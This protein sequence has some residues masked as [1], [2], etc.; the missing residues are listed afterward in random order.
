[1]WS[2]GQDQAKTLKKELQMLLPE[3]RVFVDVDDLANLDDLEVLVERSSLV[4]VF[5]SRGF[6][7]SPNVL[8]EVRATVAS[9]RHVAVV[10]ETS[11]MHGAV[12][13]AELRAQ[14]EGCADPVVAG[15]APLGLARGV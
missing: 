5:L 2:S 12:P 6:F 11:E 15:A 9:G 3:L 13:L 14:C 1:V 8:R 7:G 10:Y 4:V